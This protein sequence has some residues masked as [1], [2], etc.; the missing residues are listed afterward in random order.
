[1]STGHRS[2]GHSGFIAA[3]SPHLHVADAPQVAIPDG[4]GVF[5]SG[6]A[7]GDLTTSSV[8]LWTR[9]VVDSSNQ[10]AGSDT[11]VEWQIR[12]DDGDTTRS[13]VATARADDDH[14]VHVEV[15]DLPPG[16]WCTYEFRCG[17]DRITGRTRTLPERADHLRVAIACCS[18][19]GWPGID[20]YAAI[21]DER[22]DLLIHLGDSIYEIGETPT[23]G[24]TTDPP[25]DCHSLADYRR[26]HRQHRGRASLQHLLANVPALMVWDDH[27]VV[28]NAPEPG[29]AERRRAGQRAWSEWMPMRRPDEYGPLDRT[30]SIEGLVDLALVDS[31]F[32]GRTPADTDGPATEPDSI[33]LLDEQQWRRLESTASGSNAPWLVVANQVQIGPMTLAARPAI[34]WPP[35]RRIFNPDQWDGFPE[36]RDRLYRAL[37]TASGRP[38]VL[39]GDLHSSWSRSLRRDR[40]E[41]AHEFTCP[42]IS[43]T[44]YAT[45]VRE[46]AHLPVPTAA[47]EAWLRLLNRGI[48]HLDLDRHGFMLCDITPDAFTSTFVMADGDRV[49]RNLTNDLR[50]H[51]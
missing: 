16:T 1:M 22:P 18:R 6:V 28:D 2:I 17:G 43:G 33:E 34:H 50:T 40:H 4:S 45:A 9:V 25:W 21:V 3:D 46:R 39:S 42:S 51:R 37:G 30:V 14:C 44:P 29:G 15:T 12:G 19:W 32:A 26:R 49:V 20:L 41:V 47:L 5:A 10:V 24:T 36:A 23:G 7:S 13:G 48:D 31:R 35:W 27:E 8:V 38:V 11:A